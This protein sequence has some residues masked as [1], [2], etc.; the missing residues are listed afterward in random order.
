MLNKYRDDEEEAIEEQRKFRDICWG[1]KGDEYIVLI[2][3]DGSV[4]VMAKMNTCWGNCGCCSDD[5]R[6][7][8]GKGIVK[9]EV[10]KV[11]L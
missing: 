8:K 5:D 1:L 6:Y 2:L 10:R 7:E 3:E 11:T 4:R 9:Y